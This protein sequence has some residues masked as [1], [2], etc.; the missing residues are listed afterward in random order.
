MEPS[1]RKNLSVAG[2]AV[3]LL[4]ILTAESSQS[5]VDRCNEHLSGSYS[6]VCFGLIHDGACYKACIDESSDNIS[7]NCNLFKCW[8]YTSCDTKIVAPAGAPIL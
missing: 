1:L 5:F 8:C 6:G 4:I 2:V 3:V 7:G